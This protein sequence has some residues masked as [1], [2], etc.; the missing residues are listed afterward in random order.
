MPRP[1]MMALRDTIDSYNPA[2]P[3]AE[4]STI[5]ASWYLDADV[6]ELERRTVFS[7]SW[8]V[9]ARA[10]Q[11]TRPGQFVTCEVA[12]EPLVIARGEDNVLRGFFNV[13]RHHAAAVMT[14]AAG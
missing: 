12:G 8:Q 10:E 9:A 7:R 13:C 11:V 1:E 4:A 5:P 6:A 3:L 14:E 2:A